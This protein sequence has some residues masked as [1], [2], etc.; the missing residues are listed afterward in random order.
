MSA[1]VK[2]GCLKSTLSDASSTNQ[3]QNINIRNYSHFQCNINHF[4]CFWGHWI[5]ILPQ[6]FA[7]HYYYIEYLETGVEILF[8]KI[9]NKLTL[10][11]WKY[12]V[13]TTRFCC[14]HNIAFMAS[15][16]LDVSESGLGTHQFPGFNFGRLF[17]GRLNGTTN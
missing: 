6:N 8:L 5:W 2:R 13:P 10:F 3:A 14:G 7:G 9:K 16:L 1:F 17:N 4:E 11:V 15:N 12:C